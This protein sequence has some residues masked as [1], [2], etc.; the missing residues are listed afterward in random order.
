M[1]VKRR[2][3]LLRMRYAEIKATYVVLTLAN[4]GHLAGT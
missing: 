3:K 4:N 1:V 2:K